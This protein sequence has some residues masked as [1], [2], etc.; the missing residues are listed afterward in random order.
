MARLDSPVF[1]PENLEMDKEINTF[2]K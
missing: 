2:E 1:L